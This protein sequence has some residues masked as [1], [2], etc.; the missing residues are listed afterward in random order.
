MY[1]FESLI[2]RHIGFGNYDIVLIWFLFSLRKS[3]LLCSSSFHLL[4][5]GKM[6]P[7]QYKCCI[8]TRFS[9]CSSQEFA[10]FTG[11]CLVNTTLWICW[12]YVLT[13]QW[14]SLKLFQD[15]TGHQEFFYMWE[16]PFTL[17][18]TC[19]SSWYFKIVWAEV[20]FLLPSIC[21]V[22]QK[23]RRIKEKGTATKAKSLFA[24]A[25]KFSQKNLRTEKISW[26]II[27]I[28]IRAF[29]IYTLQLINFF[30]TTSTNKNVSTSSGCQKFRVRT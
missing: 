9:T 23:C 21:K 12:H 1:S 28:S 24:R 30:K 19:L 15:F 16:I 10:S 17:V 27:F 3:V 2:Q 7:I 13:R 11:N 26:Q 5:N 6:F 22:S 29:N 25:W 14:K 20:C 4:L 18:F 8:K